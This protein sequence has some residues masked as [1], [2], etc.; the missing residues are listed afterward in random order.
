MVFV[1]SDGGNSKHL[2]HTNVKNVIIS[3]T[4]FKLSNVGIKE[5]PLQ[6]NKSMQY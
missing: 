6:T 5:S 2:I 1:L 3:V 4:H